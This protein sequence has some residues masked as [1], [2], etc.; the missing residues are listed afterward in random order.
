MMEELSNEAVDEVGGGFDGISEPGGFNIFDTI[1]D[2]FK[3]TAPADVNT[4]P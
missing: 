3:R 2:Y 1:W 4:Q